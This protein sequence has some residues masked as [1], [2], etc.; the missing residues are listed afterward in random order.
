M[1]AQATAE[2]DAEAAKAAIQAAEEQASRN[3]ARAIE[4]EQKLAAEVEA[5]SVA[6]A[7]HSELAVCAASATH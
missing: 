7:R 2:R 1:Q 5:H 3:E 6:D 4:A